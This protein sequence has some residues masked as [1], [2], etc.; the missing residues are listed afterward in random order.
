M[1]SERRLEEEVNFNVAY[2]WFC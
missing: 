2:K 1:R